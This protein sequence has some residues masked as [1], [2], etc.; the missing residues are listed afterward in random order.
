[1]KKGREHDSKPLDKGNATLRKDHAS[2]ASHEG[3]EALAVLLDQIIVERVNK[4][5]E[6]FAGHEDRVPV[7]LLQKNFQKE[8]SG[9]DELGVEPSKD[10]L[11]GNRGHNDTWVLVDELVEEPLKVLEPPLLRVAVLV[12]LGH[13]HN[14]VDCVVSHLLWVGDADLAIRALLSC[15]GLVFRDHLVNSLLAL[16][17]TGHQRVSPLLKDSCGRHFSHCTGRKK[18]ELT[19]KR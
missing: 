9:L 1:M 2:D 16:G 18:G 8:A 15:E 4:A 5:L 6:I 7:D 14:L 3:H 13:H 10:A 11:L 17:Q 12:V 19:R